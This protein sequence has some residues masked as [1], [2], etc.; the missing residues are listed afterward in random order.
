[1]PG[2]ARVSVQQRLRIAPLIPEPIRLCQQAPRQWFESKSE[3][4][5]G[6]WPVRTVGFRAVLL[7][8]LYAKTAWSQ[9]LAARQHQSDA[10]EIDDSL[11]EGK[12][13]KSLAK[14]I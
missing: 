7:A 11:T 10:I 13:Q 3:T 6:E 12:P 14:S 9:S 8:V 4:P 1:M 5:Q 2:R